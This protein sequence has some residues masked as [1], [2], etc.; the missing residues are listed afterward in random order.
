MNT[1][2]PPLGSGALLGWR[3]DRAVY[4]ASWDSGEGAWRYGGRWNSRGIRAVYCALDPATALLEVAV[5]MGF[6]SLDTVPHVLTALAIAKPSA[7]HVVEPNMLDPA[8]LRPGLPDE[9]QQAFGDGLLKARDF[10]AIPSAVSRHS[11]N[12][13]FDSTRARGSY[14]LELQ[15]NFVLDP[16][17]HGKK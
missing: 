11:W 10:I 16:R 14:T 17:L 15:E 7:I 4:K 8:W 3:L 5:H 9:K 6:A 13:V 2:P 12:L 1:L